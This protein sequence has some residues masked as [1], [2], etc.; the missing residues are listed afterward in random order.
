MSVSTIEFMPDQ[1]TVEEIIQKYQDKKLNLTPGFQRDSVWKISDRAKLIDSIIK[2][3]PLPSVFLYRRESDGEIFYDVID[4]KQRIESILMYM[5]IIRGYKYPALLHLPDTQEPE[6][7]YYHHIVNRK[8][9][10]LINGYKLQTIEVRGDL[11]DIIDLFVRINST[12]KALTSA[13]KRHAKYYNSSLLKTAASL[14]DKNAKYLIDSKILSKDKIN[15]MKHVELILEI[16]ISIFTGDVI[17]KKMSLDKV[18][19]SE[20]F[21]ENQLRNLRW[22]TQY[23]INLIRRSFPK[24]SQ[25]RFAKLSDFYSLSVLYAKFFDEKFILTDRKRNQLAWDLLSVFSNGVDEVSHKQ[26]KAKSI[27]KGLEMQRE[28]L[29]TVIQDSDSITQRRNRENILRNLLQNLFE[30]KDS[31]R[32]FSFEQRRLLWNTSAS[33]KCVGIDCP[34]GNKELTWEDFTIDHINP[35]SKGGRSEL[36][37]AA[38]MCKSCNSKK[39]NRKRK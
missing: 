31:N 35:Y 38:L 12:G 16:M 36:D 27:S 23:I 22:K 39:G 10:N 33:R 25:S 13:E 28:Y 11:S 1:K 18:M 34:N 26:R 6:K 14:A 9:Q 37:N 8:R 4:G 32:T 19:K 30:R 29:L 15:R 7:Y 2:N 21:T 3:Y 5:G 17:N 20:K 24:I